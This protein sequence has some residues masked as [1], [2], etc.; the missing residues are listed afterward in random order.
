M[1][2]SAQTFEWLADIPQVKT[3][4]SLDASLFY[5]HSSSSLPQQSLLSSEPRRP[6]SATTLSSS[7]V[8][9]YPAV[10]KASR[11]E[12]NGEHTS[13]PSGY[14][15]GWSS[16]RMGTTRA[17]SDGDQYYRPYTAQVRRLPFIAVSLLTPM[18]SSNLAASPTAPPTTRRLGLRHPRAPATCTQCTASWGPT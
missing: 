12:G 1:D 7:R 4:P 9:P 18:H 14:T 5:S 6:R 13:M 8:R 3:E 15:S 17:G 10:L 2:S 11:S 16:P